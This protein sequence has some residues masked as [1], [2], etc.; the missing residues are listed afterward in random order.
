MTFLLW[1]IGI[2]VTVNITWRLFGNRIVNFGLK[3]MIKNLAKHSEEQ[4]EAYSRFYSEE[5]D[6]EN[7]YVKKDIKVSVAK[8]QSDKKISEDDIAEDIEFE[9]LK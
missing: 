4:S 3:Q 1:F 6:R 7:V 9:E 8:N 2:I 5:S